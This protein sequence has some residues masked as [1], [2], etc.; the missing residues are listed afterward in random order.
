MSILI[1]GLDQIIIFKKTSAPLTG[2]GM[3]DINI[4]KGGAILIDGGR[5]AAIGKERDIKKHKLSKKARHIKTRG[6]ALPGFVDSHTHAIFA[7]PR[8]KDFSMR[9]S[10]A[11]Y[12]EIKAS[13][14]GIVSS[15]KSVRRQSPA[16]MEKQ[17][18]G[19]AKKF[20]ECG[21]VT[22]EVKTGYGLD[23][24]SEIKMLQV[25]KKASKKTSL[26]M[27]ATLLSAH[28][29]PPEFK[30]NNKKYL[31]FIIAEIL[32][33]V[34]QKK[35]AAFADIFCEKGYFSPIESLDY[36]KEVKKY[37]LIGKIHAEQLS[38]YGGI[39]AGA[40]TGA[41]SA[42]HADYANRADMEVAKQ[43]EMIL[44]LLPAS[45]FYLGLRKYPN[46]RKMIDSGVAVA[47][48]T[49]FNPGTSPCWNMQEVLSLACVNMNMT[50]EETI[51][52]STINGAYALN[53][54][55]KTGSLEEGKQA[56]IAIF[57]AE[58]YREIAYYFGGN[59]NLMTIKKG[60]IVYKKCA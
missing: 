35:L 6:V 21:T 31:E 43:T 23:F 24:K 36:L 50:P 19:R 48:A 39:A 47:L 57:D 1:T 59:L 33:F 15:I 54:G 14:G 29:V 42:D 40:C 37:G 45:N 11:S 58:D 46:A 60:K 13:G 12:R 9:V 20:L 3:R 38:S 2:K 28:S 25:L 5:I 51:I 53:M 55:E 27:P 18:I 41:I 7:E 56:D 4:L 30:G 10:G 17:L 49:D 22:A 16:L 44:T 32:P 52:A 8:L 26:E 34:A